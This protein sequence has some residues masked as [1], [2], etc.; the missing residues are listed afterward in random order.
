MYN[1]I[2]QVFDSFNP[3]KRPLTM[4]Y[5]EKN[6]FSMSIMIIF[7]LDENSSGTRF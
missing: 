4:K 1:L 6:I 2:F 5:I 7:V 3:F